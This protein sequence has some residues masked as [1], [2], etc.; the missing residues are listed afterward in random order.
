MLTH[1]FLLLSHA[2]CFYTECYYAECLYTECCYA[3][4][5]GVCQDAS[6]LKLKVL[7][8]ELQRFLSN[9]R[10]V[11]PLKLFTLAIHHNYKCNC[12]QLQV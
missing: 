12:A 11:C 9:L 4:C 1:V 7:K 3:E 6:K 5:R 2:E 10:R 8:L